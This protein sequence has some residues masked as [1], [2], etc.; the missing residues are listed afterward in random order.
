MAAL[1]R[2]S[3]I[4]VNR[5]EALASL[6]TA[7]AGPRAHRRLLSSRERGESD[8]VPTHPP[9]PSVET[10]GGQPSPPPTHVEQGLFSRLGRAVS[11]F[12]SMVGW[13]GTRETGHVASERSAKDGTSGAPN[14]VGW[15]DDVDADVARRRRL[16]LDGDAMPRAVQYRH[17]IL[18]AMRESVPNV[19]EAAAWLVAMASENLAI[20][21]TEAAHVLDACIRSESSGSNNHTSM[22]SAPA[23]STPQV[24]NPAA[25]AA[26]LRAMAAGGL[27]P[28]PEALTA[29]LTLLAST[30]S[31]PHDAAMAVNLLLA[32]SDA[33]AAVASWSVPPNNVLSALI[34]RAEGGDGEW[35]WTG[36]SG[37]SKDDAS[38]LVSALGSAGGP[39][40]RELSMLLVARTIQRCGETK[41]Q[42]SQLALNLYR[43]L[44]QHVKE[45]I[46]MKTV[47][48][49]VVAC[50]GTPHV[51]DGGGEAANAQAP[52]RA[53]PSVVLDILAENHHGDRL[54]E[55]YMYAA[56]MVKGVSVDVQASVLRLCVLAATHEVVTIEGKTWNEKTLT[57]IVPILP[58][59]NVLVSACDHIDHSM[60][61]V[62]H[63]VL[64]ALRAYRGSYQ[65][66]FLRR[67]EPKIVLPDE[68]P[69]LVPPG[70][71]PEEL[72]AWR[73][74][75]SKI[76]GLIITSYAELA[77]K[78]DNDTSARPYYVPVQEPSRRA[79]AVL[80]RME[81]SGPL[82]NEYV[83]RNNCIRCA[84][85]S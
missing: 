76:F 51:R 27:A 14:A 20:D 17:H 55:D 71:T 15:W 6:A 50:L 24:G 52:F 10:A 37:D 65:R 85:W 16:I 47:Y 45:P 12:S 69:H 83:A 38:R 78:S 18:G 67:L 82:P 57:R 59:A 75:L 81:A 33:N 41:P 23:T 11:A 22:R 31:S 49:T 77:R 80:E 5:N 36:A 62:F 21:P 72:A 73:D 30:R 74:D 66:W 29:A 3:S 46:D 70:T 32:H 28:T 4:I 53:S 34:V 26:C 9:R 25:T 13:S 7:L 54:N 19:S 63:V 35:W 68:S 48:A 39:L 61:S 58:L 44:K 2:C 56:A 8:S 79:L 84:G 64:L 1:R 40:P 60:I 42:R 43:G